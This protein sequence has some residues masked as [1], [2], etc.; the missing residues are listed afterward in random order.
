MG[1]SGSGKTTLLNFLGGRLEATN[2]KVEGE[3]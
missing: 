2:M 1:P 3:I